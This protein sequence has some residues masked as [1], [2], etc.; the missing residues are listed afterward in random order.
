[1]NRKKYF[2]FL[3]FM[4]IA[5]SFL[6]LVFNNLPNYIRSHHIWT[7]LWFLSI[8][9]F[10]PK[11]ISNKSIL[12]L[13]FY[14]AVIVI[15]LNTFWKTMD[16]WNKSMI[17]NEFYQISVGLT[18]FIYYKHSKDYAGLAHISKWGV[19]F[20]IITAVMTIVSSII[21]PMYARKI[22]GLASVSAESLREEYLGIKKVG[23]GGYGTAIAF[24]SLIPIIIAV[25]KHPTEIK[26][27]RVLLLCII[28]LF[29]SALLGIQLFAN[30]L[31]AFLFFVLA[32]FG[33][34]RLKKVLPMAIIVYAALTLLPNDFYYNALMG[35]SNLFSDDSNVSYKLKDLATYT[36]SNIEWG[37]NST[38]IGS[39][40]TRYS[41]LAGSF[42]Q[43]P[44]MGSY[45]LNDNN[46]KE[47]LQ[48]SLYYGS[49]IIQVEGTHI[50]WMNKLTVTGIVGFL[51]FFL[52]IYRFLK[53]INVDMRSVLKY[54]FILA[55]FSILS[56]GLIK[57]IAGREAWYSFF[58][59]IP[60]LYF[61][62][63]NSNNSLR[64]LTEKMENNQKRN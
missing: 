17:Y 21:D 37:D 11:M 49:G 10:Y 27:N 57:T 26:I 5:S 29:S 13:L 12:Y 36:A 1:M 43:S 35:T 45:F 58:I 31:L 59:I 23:G 8:I 44:L 48:N 15:G 64:K 24:M 47:Y 30:I 52:I 46:A 63:T 53:V 42:F 18:V 33:I 25:F 6:P 19:I 7:I 16:E 32:V 62:I 54:Y 34:Q 50:H 41:Q 55:L 51:F 56:Y 4:I 2:R 20:L 61:Y 3:S 22:V 39:R 60:G 28:F 40:A 14:G 38:G 9:V